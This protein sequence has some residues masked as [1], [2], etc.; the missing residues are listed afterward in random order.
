MI[1]G[2]LVLPD[3][4]VGIIRRI[5]HTQALYTT[6][7]KLVIDHCAF[8]RPHP[9]RTHGVIHRLHDLAD[10]RHQFLIRR[11]FGRYQRPLP[12]AAKCIGPIDLHGQL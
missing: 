1:T 5:D 9:A 10:M 12:E 4:T 8:V 6:Y 7:L 11:A 3:T 2:A